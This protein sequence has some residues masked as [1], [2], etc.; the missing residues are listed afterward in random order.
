MRKM[1]E[2][3]IEKIFV[4]AF[5]NDYIDKLGLNDKPFKDKNL[6]HNKSFEE[7]I[8]LTDKEWKSFN[9]PLPTF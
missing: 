6:K 9:F 4:D 5:G 8:F 1:T 3:E 2:E 7:N